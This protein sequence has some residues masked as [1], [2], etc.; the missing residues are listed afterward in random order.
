MLHAKKILFAL[1]LLLA[2]V[3]GQVAQAA[4][5]TAPAQKETAT[6]GARDIVQEIINV[7]GLKPRFELRAADIDNAVAVIYNGKRYILYSERF[8]SEINNAVHTD[9]AGVSIL[10][11]EI[12]HHL[13]GH[14]L[15][16]SGSN[17]A[18][19]LEADEFSGFVLRKM[20]A[21]M[22]EAQAAIDLLSEDHTSRTHP[23]RSYRLAAISKGW[24]SA[25]DQLKMIAKAPQPDERAIVSKPSQRNTT[26]S[27]LR[28]SAVD[29]RYVLT[30]VKF[31]KAPQEQFFV[32]NNLNLVHVT[33]NG[34]KVIGKLARTNNPDFPYYFKSE[35]LKPVFISEEGVLV[36]EEGQRVG[37][38]ST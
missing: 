22:A 11:H 37:H 20:G 13:N 26:G 28:T 12:G 21:S 36:N 18:D 6:D 14:T 38:L 2:P 33:A 9:W 8:L 34:Y 23:G 25:D 32:T 10:A 17:P 5:E 15:S 19:E 31:T 24:H 4:T 3:L 29:S 30:R 16:R 7:V 1:G 35:Y 27:V